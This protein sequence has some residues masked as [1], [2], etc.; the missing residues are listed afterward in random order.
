MRAAASLQRRVLVLVLGAVALV[1]LATGVVIW[2]ESA[3]ELSEL[4]DGHL[5]QAA[6][7]L[8]VQQ[9]GESLEE[10]EAL[11]DAP[12]LHRYAPRVIFQVWH[13]GVLVRRSAQAPVTPL[14]DA[15]TGYSDPLINGVAWRVFSAHGSEGDVVVHV[16]ERA[17]ARSEIL[18]SVLRSMLAA[19]LVA[20]PLLAVLVWVAVRR[21]ML[22]LREL[23]GALRGRT[24]QDLTPMRLRAA[25]VEIAPVV[26]ALNGLFG[27]ID[28]VLA[29]ER[30]FTADAAHELRTPI[31]AIRAQAQVAM[32]AAQTDERQHA[33]QATLAGCDRAAR[34]VDQLLWLAR[35]ESGEAPAQ[36]PLDLAALVRGVTAELAAQ[37]LD[38][39]QTLELDA[40]ASRPG[41]GNEALLRALV[42]NFVDNAIRYA[43][44]HAQIRVRVPA[45]GDVWL[46]VED[47]GPGMA[48]ADLHRLGERF[49]RGAGQAAPGSGLGWSIATRIAQVHGCTVRVDRSPAWG[50]LRVQVGALS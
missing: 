42:R 7:L 8:V 1:W 36:V 30:R 35:V 19:L 5:A 25:P 48:E 6:A 21:G 24:P 41:A 28:R 13:G 46:T 12:N 3:H 9:A 11:A 16:G 4:L 2:R 27:R 49:F 45:S 14:A 15:D 33:L 18:A 29:T 32:Q 47:N 40:P 43:P 38:K 34:L 23:T 10:D 39:A 17:Q 37:A 20:L 50:G 44:P 26:D 22:P 31:A